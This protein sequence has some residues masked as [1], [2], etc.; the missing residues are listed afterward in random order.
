[1]IFILRAAVVLSDLKLG[2]KM[3]GM[4]RGSVWGKMVGGAGR[5]RGAWLDGS[6]ECATM[7]P[8]PAPRLRVRVG[9][10]YTQFLYQK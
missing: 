7:P 3:M 6:C 8:L 10:F 2:L 5:A 9:T 4:Y 1:M